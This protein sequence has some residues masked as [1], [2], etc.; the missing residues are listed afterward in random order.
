MATDGRAWTANE[1]RAQFID[2]FVKKHNH[3]NWPSSPVVPHDDPTL[4][5]AN[6]GMNQFKPC[7]LGQVDPKSEMAKLRRVCNTQKCI[8]AGG[9]H[10]DLD[11]V[12]KDTYHHTFFEMLGNWSIGDY[13]KEEAIGMAFE[14]LVDVFKLPKE[15]LYATYFGGDAKQN[16]PAD[17][18]AR[19][20]WL[21]YLPAERVLPFGMKDNFWEMG[22]VGPCGPCTEIHYDRIGGRDASKMVNADDPTVIEIWNNVFIQFNRE[23]D[24][25]LK[26]LPAKHVDTGMGF[27]RL[28]S[29]L[30]NKMSN[31]DTDVFD[32]L[33]KAIKKETGARDYAGK[34]G[35]EDPDH[36]DTAYRVVADHVRTLTFAITDGAVPSNEGRGYVLRRI[37]RRAV[38]YGSVLG[39]KIGFFSKLVP[40]VV[41]TMGGVFPE[42]RKAPERVIDIIREEELQFGRTLEKGIEKFNKAAAE[43]LK[44]GKKEIP[45]KDVFTL[46]DT[47]GFPVDLTQL[48]SEERG[49]KVDMDGYRAA[50]EHAKELSRSAQKGAERAIVLE[51]EQTDYLSKKGI[52][53][54]EDGAKYTWHKPIQATVKAIYNLAGFHD[55]TAGEG[56]VYGIVLDRTSFYAESGG[57]VYDT[58]L[59]ANAQ[60]GVKFVVQNVQSF[61]AYILHIGVVTAGQLRLGDEV[62]CEVDY[63]RRAMVAPNHTMTHVLNFALRKILGDGVDQ[64]GSLVT[65]EKLRF[66]FSYNGPVEASKLASIENIVRE[67][68]SAKLD[69]HVAVA[70][71]TAAK[72]IGSLRAVFGEVYPDPVRVV[73]VGAPVDQM[74]SDPENPKWM[75]MSVEFCGGT[76]L[77]N[78]SEAEGFALIS[79]EGIAKGIRRIVGFTG[80]AALEAIATGESLENRTKAAA[81]LALQSSTSSDGVKELTALSLVV[82]TAQI[83]A[84]RKK[85]IKDLIDDTQRKVLAAQ[86]KAAED[87]VK[88]AETTALDLGEKAN[89][90]GQKFV[91]ARI[92]VGLNAAGVGKLIDAIKSKAAAA[93]VLLFSADPSAGKV[94][95]VASV[96]DA[97]VAT[98]NAKDW[99]G[100]ALEILGGKGGG[101]P[102]Y[103]Q[104][105]GSAIDKV[106]DAIS[107][108]EKMA[109]LKL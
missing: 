85:A 107:A 96:P 41:E 81:S 2:F 65:D 12:G 26:L 11:D 16:L 49:L 90:A 92:D 37:L 40:V 35:K 50:M 42:L 28:T 55:A 44:A 82:D 38:R 25:S 88:E 102:N 29:I 34:L 63:A 89:A 57:Q 71:L 10:N 97:A 7:F 13:F 54:S 22:D 78:T 9:K 61:G 8:R 3:V 93:P 24:G 43:V 15:R 72:R 17:D 83:P 62:H 104:G 74:L 79:E 68:I 108:A 73:S 23:H 101:K 4:L 60:M 84:A 48:M 52:A 106:S 6:A 59:L 31:Y 91:V 18:E 30:Q 69:V 56:D 70:P 14:L 67:R 39:G 77:T 33:F 36:I 51:A 66:D 64:K 32:P 19:S 105:Q 45:G 95:A 98:L 58:G 21:K 75:D 100:A 20:I 109:A 53:P 46:Y 86:K 47:Y 103:A 1:I 27:E 5:F 87:K 76:H 80:Q 94:M 99:V